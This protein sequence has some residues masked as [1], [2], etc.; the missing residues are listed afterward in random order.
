MPPMPAVSFATDILPLFSTTTD[1]PH[2]A[3]RGFML[4]DYT[5]MSV[6]THAQNVLDHLTGTKRPLM[7]PRPEEPWSADN[8]ALFK[9]WIAGGYQP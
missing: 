2:M 3:Q 1:I 5:Y 7:P 4:A 8:I 9:A 6:P